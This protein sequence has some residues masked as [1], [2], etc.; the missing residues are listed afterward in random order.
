MMLFL[1]E[2]VFFAT[3]TV[4]DFIIQLHFTEYKE[5]LKD[6]YKYHTVFVLQRTG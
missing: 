3:T 4:C 6:E 1:L 2:L 5:R